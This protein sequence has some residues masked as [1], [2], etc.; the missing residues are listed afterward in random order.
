M[1]AV[2]EGLDADAVAGEPEFSASRRPRGRRRTSR[3]SRAR[4]S[5]PH[6][7]KAWT[8]TSVSEWSVRQRWPPIC[9]SSARM[10][11]VVVDLAVEDEAEA[12]VLVGHRLRCR[13][14]ERSMMES[15]R[16]PRPI[17]PPG[18]ARPRRRPGRGGPWCPASARPGPRKR[19]SHPFRRPG[20]RLSRTWARR[21]LPAA[22]SAVFLLP[23]GLCCLEVLSV[24]FL[25]YGKRVAVQ[26]TPLLGGPGFKRA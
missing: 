17:R 26:Q 14:A 1:D 8:I 22:R 13:G 7:S 5:M 18:T 19:G 10:L 16:C 3:G 9:S 4:Q 6:S 2:V 20:P 12:A 15:R 21:S 24:E 25:P 11:G 23:C